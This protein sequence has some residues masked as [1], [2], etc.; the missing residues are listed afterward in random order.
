MFDCQ[1]LI[2]LFIIKKFDIVDEGIGVP[3]SEMLHIFGPFVKSSYTKKKTRN[4]GI[5][6]ALTEKIIKIHQGI[7]GVSN[8]TEKRGATFSFIIPIR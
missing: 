1:F 7:I 5:G 6:L 3:E 4:A 8:N 2:T